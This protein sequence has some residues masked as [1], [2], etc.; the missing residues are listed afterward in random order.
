[1]AA[2][3]IQD[4]RRYRQWKARTER[5]PASYRTTLEALQRY[6]F[7]FGP[8]K[9]DSVLAMLDDLAELFEQSAAAGTPIRT[10]VGDDPVEFVEA[11]VA[12][13]PTGSWIRRERDR[14][15]AAV[16]RAAAGDPDAHDSRDDGADR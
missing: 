15:N 5:L 16:D 4:K 11:F 7:L 12:N 1:M 2:R 14:L 6:M 9:G 13:Y 3:W 8:S 10:V